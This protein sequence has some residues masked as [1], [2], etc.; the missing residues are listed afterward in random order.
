MGAITVAIG[1]SDTLS[2][3]V[4]IL[5]SEYVTD[6]QLLIAAGK[7]ARPVIIE[8]A[9][10]LFRPK[11]LVVALVDPQVETITELK[12]QI[13]MLG[14]EL[15]VIIYFTKPPEGPLPI[16]A[17]TVKIEK[18]EK[19]RLKD[20]I[21]RFL[22]PFGKVMTDKAFE[23]FAE[24][25]RDEMS[26][27]QEL[28]KLVNFIGERNRIQSGDVKALTIHSHD[29]Q[30]RDLFDAFAQGDRQRCLDVLENL[31]SQG[32]PPIVIQN[33]LARQV[34]LLM[35]ARDLPEPGYSATDFPSFKKAFP[36]LKEGLAASTADR[37]AY[38]A[39]Q[40]PYYAFLLLQA[41]RR[42]PKRDLALLFQRLCDFDLAVKSGGTKHE[43]AFLE[44]ILFT[45]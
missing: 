25:L 20:R 16:K 37:K 33:Y 9:S 30:L 42:I 32:L 26:L 21:L 23:A 24:A 41:A 22:K 7:E 34:R 1:S 13:E 18:D 40:H 35:Q 19:K 38:L 8:Q 12:A 4:R 15:P 44:S 31:F 2:E 11:D 39:Y 5:A 27:E 28:M 3:D 10:A 14:R 6:P 36:R 29:D 43:K 45:R 17:T